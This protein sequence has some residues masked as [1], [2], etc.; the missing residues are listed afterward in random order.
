M[1]VPKNHLIRVRIQVSFILKEEAGDGWLLQI[2]WH[3][4]PLFLQL[5]MWVKSKS[6]HK[7]P[8]GQM[9]FSVLQLSLALWMEACYTFKD[10][11]LEKGISCIFWVVGSNLLQRCRA[12]VTEY[13]RQ[14]TKVRAKGIDSIWSQVCSSLLQFLLANSATTGE[15]FDSFVGGLL[16]EGLLWWLRW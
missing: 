5:F 11:S 9:L 13:R 10:Q 14:N 2:S 6:S 12:I 8:T 3:Q 7:P 16:K 4:N 15:D 1:S